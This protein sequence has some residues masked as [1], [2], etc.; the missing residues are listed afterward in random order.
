MFESSVVKLGTAFGAITEV[1]KLLSRV[2]EEVGGFSIATYDVRSL[3]RRLVTEAGDCWVAGNVNERML[4]ESCGS[5]YYV[6]VTKESVTQT[7]EL[8]DSATQ[9]TTPLTTMSSPLPPLRM[10]AKDT[11]P[12][13]SI[14]WLLIHIA[15]SVLVASIVD[16][17]LESS[18]PEE[19]GN[20][21]VVDGL[22]DLE[23][24]PRLSVHGLGYRGLFIASFLN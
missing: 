24:D 16:L 4:G 2:G 13:S 15:D 21:V 23:E 11:K 20:R 5:E 12:I 9:F 8:K 1:Q 10:I 17:A 18:G 6:S 22:W 3:G 7:R 19:E 14:S